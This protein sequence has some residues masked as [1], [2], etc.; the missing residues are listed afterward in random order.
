MKKTPA[1]LE[2]TGARVLGGREARQTTRKMSRGLSSSTAVGRSRLSCKAWRGPSRA[3]SSRLERDPVVARYPPEGRRR[4]LRPGLSRESF[5]ARQR[6]QQGED[7]LHEALVL[8]DV[9]PPDVEVARIGEIGHVR[10][11]VR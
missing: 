9:L 10:R 5:D 1:R 8:F 7:Q 4:R 2:E 6:V 11:L 3:R